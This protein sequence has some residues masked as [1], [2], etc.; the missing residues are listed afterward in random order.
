MKAKYLENMNIYVGTAR[1]ISS[2]YRNFSK[3]EVF[4]GSHCEFPKFNCSRM[5]GII[6][7]LG[8][9]NRRGYGI[10]VMHV[11]TTETL[12]RMWEGG[13]FEK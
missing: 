6:V 12:V 4:C 2:L 8:E 9:E 11:V 5:Y 1:E 10:P 3:R 7:D 13:D